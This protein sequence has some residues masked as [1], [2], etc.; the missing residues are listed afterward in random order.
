MYEIEIRSDIFRFRFDSTAFAGTPLE[1][2]HAKRPLVLPLQ[3]DGTGSYGQIARRCLRVAAEYEI[4]SKVERESGRVD[5]REISHHLAGNYS[6]CHSLVQ[7]D[8][9]ALALNALA[10]HQ[11]H[12]IATPEQRAGRARHGIAL[13]YRLYVDL[14][15]VDLVLSL[16]RELLGADVLRG[17]IVA[18]HLGQQSCGRS[19][20]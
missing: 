6:L 13:E 3:Y 12:H 17:A 20:S 2:L 18:N 9:G 7:L 11:Q 19:E 15:F 1:P 14:V 16:Y 4:R 5:E 8:L 10:R